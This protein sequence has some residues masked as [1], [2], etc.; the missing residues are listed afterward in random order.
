MNYRVWLWMM[1]LALLSLFA[2]REFRERKP[3]AADK[4]E[5]G[6]QGLAEVNS[7][8]VGWRVSW[9][10]QM[11]LPPNTPAVGVSGKCLFLTDKGGTVTALSRSGSILWRKSLDLRSF[12]APALACGD[13]LALAAVDGDVALLRKEDGDTVWSVKLDA[14]FQHKP[15]LGLLVNGIETLLVVSQSDGVIFCLSMRDGSLLWKS[16]PTNRFDGEPVLVGE[17]IVYGNCDGAVHVFDAHSG[18][19]LGSVKLGDNDQMA[20][21]LLALDGGILCA[22]TRQG[23]LVAV[24]VLTMAHLSYAEVSQTEAFLT[25][26][27]AFGGMVAMGSAEGVVSFWNFHGSVLESAGKAVFPAEVDGL[28]SQ[29]GRLFVLSDGAFHVL[30]QPDETTFSVKLG[31]DI[32]GLLALG[33]NAAVCVADGALVFLEGEG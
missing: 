27:M 8:K 9:R 1:P 23:R 2:L 3:A 30:D 31:D 22:G 7:A 5:R 21:G 33:K 15:L 10:V 24:N 25:P 17:R 18:A 13:C 12:A 19:L 29:G 28:V 16:E 4:K 6:L 32:H 11:P 26:V 14:R 20:G